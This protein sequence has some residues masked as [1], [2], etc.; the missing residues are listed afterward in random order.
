MEISKEQKKEFAKRAKASVKNYRKIYFS[1]RLNEDIAN[2][3]KNASEAV[4]IT[5]NALI[6]RAL[7]AY[8][9]RMDKMIKEWKQQNEKTLNNG[10][11][12]D[13]A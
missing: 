2:T 7:V 8:Q 13:N 9:N 6:E 12:N 4:G 10:V 3:V 5:Y 11:E 1:I